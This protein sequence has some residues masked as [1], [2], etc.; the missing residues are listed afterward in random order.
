MREW[1]LIIFLVGL[2]GVGCSGSPAPTPSLSTEAVPS[3]IPSTPAPVELEEVVL[4]ADLDEAPERWDEVLFIPFGEAGD[5]LGYKPSRESPT[6]GP[7]AFAFA[8]DGTV[9]IIDAAKMRLVHFSSQRKL[10]GDVH[11]LIGSGSRDLAFVGDQ[12]FSI[13]LYHKGVVYEIEDYQIVE[14][15][16]IRKGIKS[17]YVSDFVPTDHGLHAT[18]GGYTEPVAT[19][20]KGTYRVF[21]PGDGQIESVPGLPLKSG[22]SFWLTTRDDRHFRLH[23]LEGGRETV[24][25]LR[26]DVVASKRFGN[27]RM[28]G[29]VGLG[30]FVL[31][32]NDVFMHVKTAVTRPGTDADQIGGRFLLRVGESPILFERLPEPTRIDDTQVRHIALGPD[33]HLYLMRLDKDGVRIFR[34]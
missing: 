12:L 24:Q 30:D 34:R 19:G 20:P 33:G 27:R 6:I 17:V 15:H 31:D 3:P 28:R 21:L 18:I 11:A 23:Y 5:E 22:T 32:G 14:T 10:L 13:G 26:I 4:V 8:G 2:L 16:T 9:W 7:N 25:P 29:V 1:G